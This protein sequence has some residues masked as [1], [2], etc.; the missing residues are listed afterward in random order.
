LQSVDDAIEK[1]V[2]API[3]VSTYRAELQ[4]IFPDGVCDYPL[5]DVGRPS[6]IW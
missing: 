4:R 1:G 3:D 2:Y 6:A 5:G